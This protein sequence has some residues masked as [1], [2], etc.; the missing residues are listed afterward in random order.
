MLP[1]IKL[2][3]VTKIYQLGSTQV[4][5]LRG[6]HF[7]LKRSEVT[8]IVGV[9]GSGKSTL[10]NIIGF[11]DQCTSGRYVFDGMDVSNLSNDEEAR[12]RN[13]K[14]G[15][16]FQSFFLLPRF[17]ALQNVMLPL[18]YRGTPKE[19]SKDRALRLLDKM[20]VLHVA[21]HKP[22]QLSGGQQQRVAIA[23]AL[24]GDPEVILA[25]EPTGALDTQTGF[26]VMER[27]TELNRQEG[28][29]IVIITHDKEISRRCERVVTIKDGEL[30]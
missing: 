1:L 15:F 18:F 8:A 5:A 9:S 22:H 6:I 10:M 30:I 27:F 20:G 3:N 23:R 11:L 2:E 13:Q 16:V 7:E 19:E 14:I 17:T 25:D 21:A 12:I 4:T 28:R 24:V 26:D 29:T